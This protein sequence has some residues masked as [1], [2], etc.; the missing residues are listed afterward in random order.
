MLF[1]SQLK[2]RVGA[3]TLHVRLL[4]GEQR[5]RAQ[6]VL[7][8]TLEGTVHLAADPLAL[9]MLLATPAGATDV[10]RL[11]G[12]A[13]TQLAEARV[14]VAEVTLGQPSLDEA[15]LALTGRVAGPAI[16]DHEDVNA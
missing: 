11:V 8:D 9:S 5:P 10:A 4:D 15:F 7:A 6:R 12:T 14:G 2:S 13:M 1:R 3:G 16:T